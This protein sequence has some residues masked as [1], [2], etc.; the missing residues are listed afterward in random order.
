[1][2]NQIKQIFFSINN[3]Q[4]FWSLEAFFLWQN[5][6]M[7]EYF[8]LKTKAVDKKKF[9]L[10]ASK[11]K[12]TLH[13][14]VRHRKYFKLFAREKGWRWRVLR[15]TASSGADAS[16]GRRPAT[17]PSSAVV[18]QPPPRAYMCFCH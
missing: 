17:T 5:L 7:E 10:I 8:P 2:N 12:F 3:G 13:L 15:R 9:A 16:C 11:S 1:M 6:A 14:R 18:S 4:T